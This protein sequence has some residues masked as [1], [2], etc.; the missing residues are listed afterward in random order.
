[1]YCQLRSLILYDQI[2][3]Y[4][5]LVQPVEPHFS[6]IPGLVKYIICIFFV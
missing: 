3:A 4:K 2:T 1:M 6:N 5:F